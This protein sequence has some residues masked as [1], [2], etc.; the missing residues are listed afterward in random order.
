MH[1]LGSCLSDSQNVIMEERVLPE[2]LLGD[3]AG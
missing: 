2:G 1:T 3:A